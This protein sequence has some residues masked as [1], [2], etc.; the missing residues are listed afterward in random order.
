MTLD[1]NCDVRDR[2]CYNNEGRMKNNILQGHN[3]HR[4]LLGPYDT[5]IYSRSRA[6]YFDKTTE[7]VKVNY[8][9]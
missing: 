6:S 3:D 4:G 9:P 2:F 1:V 8:D 5:Y 7:G